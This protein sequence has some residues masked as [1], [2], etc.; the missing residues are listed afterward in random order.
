MSVQP[1]SDYELLPIY[2]RVAD[3]LRAKMDAG[4]FAVGSYLPGELELSKAFGLSRGTIRKALDI[5]AAEG[6]I[7]RQPGR[8]TVVLPVRKRATT[9]PQI[10]VVWSIIRAIGAD[11]LAGLES[12]IAQAG[13]DLLFSTSEHAPAKEAEILARLAE[14]DVAG[15]VLY[16]TGEPQNDALI[17]TI[18]ANGIPLVLI[19]RFMPALADR[20]SWVTSENEQ[21]A[22]ELTRYL[23]QLGHRRIAYALCTVDNENISTLTERRAGYLRALKDAGLN[24]DPALL[25]F[26]YGASCL[27]LDNAEVAR[28]FLVFIQQQQPTAVF[29]VNDAMALRIY[30]YLRRGGIRIPNDLSIAGFDRLRLP[31]DVNPLDLT[32]VAQDF[33]S[34]GV[35]AGKVITR[36]IQNPAHAPLH[37]R[38]PVSLYIG[39]TTAPPATVMTGQPETGMPVS[40]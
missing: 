4:E 33:N 11:M 14:S 10:A 26:I 31:Y 19:D 7:S 23:I 28:R 9:R 13:Y 32:S 2:V 37:I 27:E 22:Y 8:G 35:E 36:L 17:E 3:N 24:P 1:L 39:A 15:I 12:A 34:L 30:P 18:I 40:G 21:G 20:V 16:A 29:F 5:L 38:V 6:R 25:F